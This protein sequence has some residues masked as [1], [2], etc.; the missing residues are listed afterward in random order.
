[1]LAR[2][3]Q[4]GRELFPADGHSANYC[5]TFE[6]HQV[7]IAARPDGITLALLVENTAGL[8]LGRFRELLQG[9]LEMT[10]L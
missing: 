9:F 10:E 8:Q 5:W 2:I 7:H 1:M 4:E 6:A 3:V